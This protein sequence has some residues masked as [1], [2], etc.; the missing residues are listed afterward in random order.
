MG[1]FWDKYVLISDFLI[2]E[3]KKFDIPELDLHFF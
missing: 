2:R 1:L 3:G